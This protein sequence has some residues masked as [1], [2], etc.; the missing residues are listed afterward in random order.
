MATIN[1]RVEVTREQVEAFCRKWRV[2]RFELFGSVLRDDFDDR[3]D[4]DVLLTY[5]PGVAYDIHGQLQMEEE[6]VAMFHRKVDFVERRLIEQSRNW[7]RR[8]AILDS[9]RV[10]YARRISARG[11]H[12]SPPGA[13]PSRL[14]VPASRLR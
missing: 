10:V 11:P 4:V 6:L 9:A 13:R 2:V 5:E 14:R 8:K 1:P 12:A 7:I 3:S